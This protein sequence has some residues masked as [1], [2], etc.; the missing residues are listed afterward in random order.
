MDAHDVFL[1]QSSHQNASKKQWSAPLLKWFIPNINKG[2]T[3]WISYV[4][5]FV[6]SWFE[7]DGVDLV[8]HI[9]D[10]FFKYP[11]KSP[12][13]VAPS[14]YNL[15]RSTLYELKKFMLSVWRTL[16]LLCSCLWLWA[17]KDILIISIPCDSFSENQ[18]MI[19][20]WPEKHHHAFATDQ[21][22]AGKACAVESASFSGWNCTLVIFGSH[23]LGRKFRP[24]A[25]WK[26]C[27]N[28]KWIK[29]FSLIHK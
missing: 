24:S 18:L 5:F 22:L 17:F 4:G 1:V 6:L 20:I 7:N 28:R 10:H 21:N 25:F 12:T 19:W 9:S 8:I 23:W 15:A 11:T 2:K 16:H 27:R 3:L 26:A 29:V 14:F 13:F